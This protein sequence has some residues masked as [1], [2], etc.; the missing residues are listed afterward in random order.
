MRITLTYDVNDEVDER[1]EAIR[2]LKRIDYALVL[3]D[4]DSWLRG[5]IKH[6]DD[7]E[8]ILDTLET[9]RTRLRDL[10]DEYSVEMPE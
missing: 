2:D 5:R 3:W 7:P 9:V 8:P 10:M 6:G 4:L 1:R